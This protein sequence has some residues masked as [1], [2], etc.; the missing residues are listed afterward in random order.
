MHI[1]R[2]IKIKETKNLGVNC[3]HKKMV[4][5]NDIYIVVFV[6]PF[7]Y[8]YKLGISIGDIISKSITKSNVLKVR[9]KGFLKPIILKKENLVNILSQ[10]IIYINDKL[11]IGRKLSKIMKRLL[12]NL[13]EG[14]IN[15]KKEENIVW[16]TN[17]WFANCIKYSIKQEICKLKYYRN[18]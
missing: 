5:D 16:I 12:K 2:E 9:D 17:D 3:I 4:N 8:G 10:N 14:D 6:K 15:H 11:V 7:S 18:V 1:Y 13:N